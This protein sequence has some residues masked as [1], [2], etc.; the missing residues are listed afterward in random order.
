MLQNHFW[1]IW[2]KFQISYQIL[3]H[4]TSII[5][6]KPLSSWVLTKYKWFSLCYFVGK[7]HFKWPGKNDISTYILII[8]CVVG[9]LKG[10]I[11]YYSLIE[12]LNMLL[13]NISIW[14]PKERLDISKFF[15][16]NFQ[17]TSEYESNVYIIVLVQNRHSMKCHYL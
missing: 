16:E 11:V 12:I 13:A 5:V 2:I 3:W 10:E 7:A 8:G 9:H 17:N 1:C 4:P 6:M 15:R 14:S